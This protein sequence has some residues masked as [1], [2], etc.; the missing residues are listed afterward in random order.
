[1][2]GYPRVAGTAEGSEVGWIEDVSSASAGLYLVDVCRAGGVAA[3]A[4]RIV[5]EELSDER[6]AFGAVGL[7][8]FLRAASE[9]LASLHSPSIR[10]VSP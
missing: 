2:R 4:E 1:M 9:W 6:D 7:S 3:L 8:G 10:A 5:L